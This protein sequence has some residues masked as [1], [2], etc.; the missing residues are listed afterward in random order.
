[1]K[2]LL[3]LLLAGLLLAV[4]SSA[5]LAD[6]SASYSDGKVTVST[7]EYG[8]W[9]ITIDSEWVG[10]GVGH[11]HPSNTFSMP[12]EDG[13]HKVHIFC[14]D[15]GRTITCTFW[16]GDAQPADAPDAPDAEPTEQS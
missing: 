8:F 12:L 14:P 6:V 1:M 5:A 13:E 11:L 15:E 10:Y 2:K 16:A 9:E 3:S 7:D 4:C